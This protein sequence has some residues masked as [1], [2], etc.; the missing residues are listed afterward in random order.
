MSGRGLRNLIV[1]RLSHE[2]L[3]IN[4]ISAENAQTGIVESTDIEF[5]FLYKIQGSTFVPE[6][7]SEI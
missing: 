1:G 6:D 7:G 2:L 3:V 4:C 5:N